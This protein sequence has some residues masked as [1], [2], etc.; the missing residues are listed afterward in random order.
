MTNRADIVII[1]RSAESPVLRVLPRCM[2]AVAVDDLLN[3]THGRYCALEQSRPRDDVLVECRIFAG[4]HG[5]SE[6]G[7]GDGVCQGP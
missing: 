3:R 7:T 1:A 6:S 4:G 5:I 2:R